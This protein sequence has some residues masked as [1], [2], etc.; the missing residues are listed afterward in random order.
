[1]WIECMGTYHHKKGPAGFIFENQWNS[2]TVCLKCPGNLTLESSDFR[3]IA[4]YR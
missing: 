3:D 2:E 1:V 4:R